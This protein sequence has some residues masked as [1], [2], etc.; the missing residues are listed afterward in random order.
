MT[1]HT[2]ETG[3]LPL[4]LEALTGAV[5]VSAAGLYD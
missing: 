5:V 4:A 1:L 3:R 2:D